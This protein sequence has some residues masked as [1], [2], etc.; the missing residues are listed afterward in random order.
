MSD[1]DP[2]VTDDVVDDTDQ[3]GERLDADKVPTEFPDRPT[4]SFEHGTTAR[5]MAEGE[6]LDDRLSRE[7]PD[8]AGAARTP[9]ED[10]PAVP[11]QDDADDDGLDREK[12]LVAESPV[13]EPHVDDTG[14]PTAP[15][16][17]EEAAI[18]PE[19][20][21][22]VPGTTEHEVIRREDDLERPTDV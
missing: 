22:D 12:D 1:F 14:Q 13:A 11:L 2:T 5:E 19:A 20:T 8:D 4:A 18:R 15:V 3:P 16:A 21:D 17:A 9:A 7:L 10:T 6:S